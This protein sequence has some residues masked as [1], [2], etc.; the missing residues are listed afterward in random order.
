MT[1]GWFEL[2]AQLA[3]GSWHLRDRWH[4]FDVAA[5]VVVLR[6]DSSKRGRRKS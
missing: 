3:D 5:L 6:R 4:W 1:A 2:E